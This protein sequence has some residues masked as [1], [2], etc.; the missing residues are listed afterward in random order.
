MYGAGAAI[1]SLAHAPLWRALFVH[2]ARL[3][4][5]IVLITAANQQQ[6]VLN[7]MPTVGAKATPRVGA[8]P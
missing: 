2:P 8:M 4:C 7:C 6:T 5:K 3:S 1:A